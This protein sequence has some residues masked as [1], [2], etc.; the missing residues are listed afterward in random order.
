MALKVLEKKENKLFDR[1][2]AVLEFEFGGSTPSRKQLLPEIVSAFD[3][4]P[5]F[6]SIQKIEQRYG[7]NSVKVRARIYSS[8][9]SLKRFEPAHLAKRVQQK[10]ESKDGKSK[11]EK[12]KKEK[13]KEKPAEEAPKEEEPAEEE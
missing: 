5:E 4:K 11:Q 1:I 6:V 9:D 7:R 8:A 3:S 10:V 13:P 12:P 2:D